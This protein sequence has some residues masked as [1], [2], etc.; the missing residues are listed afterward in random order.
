MFLYHITNKKNIKSIKVY[1]LIP[2]KPCEWRRIIPPHWR[3]KEIV[4]LLGY[5]K[6]PSRWQSGNIDDSI[7][8]QINVS[9]LDSKFLHRLHKLNKEEDLEWWFFVGIIPTNAIE[10]LFP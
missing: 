1:G 5:T 7:C 2:K 6:N 3:N 9:L 10:H 4:W 8:L